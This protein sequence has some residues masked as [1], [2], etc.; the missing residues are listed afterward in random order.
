MNTNLQIFE[1]ESQTVRTVE[2]YGVVWFVAKDVAATLGYRNT[3]DAINSVCR[4]AKSLIDMGVATNDSPMDPQTKLIPESDVYRLTMKS[5]LKSA[6]RFQDWVAE[7]VL[8]AI[9]KTGQYSMP[10]ELVTPGQMFMEV[11]K[12]FLVMESR[13]LGLETKQQ[14]LE[15]RVNEA[16]PRDEYITIMGFCAKHHLKMT[17]EEKRLLGLEASKV[18]RER[19]IFI[20]EV[21]DKRYGQVHAYPEELLEELVEIESGE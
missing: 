6:E 16:L 3:R 7:E 11:A 13:L 15:D 12:Q 8:P 9:R 21:P 2:I 19:K 18:C 14:Q 17:T 10:K 1:F 5:T 4:K 20:D